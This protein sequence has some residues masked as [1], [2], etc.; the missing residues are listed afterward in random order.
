[1]QGRSAGAMGR[2]LA[3]D[4]RNRLTRLSNSVGSCV[5]RFVGIEGGPIVRASLPAVADGWNPHHAR[6]RRVV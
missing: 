5:A 3:A 2:G 6:M 4:D 1:M